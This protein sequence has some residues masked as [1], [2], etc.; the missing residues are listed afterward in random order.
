M[1]PTL[2]KKRVSGTRFAWNTG[3]GTVRNA[4]RA[5]ELRMP[6]VQKKE[7]DQKKLDRCR[8]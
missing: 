5:F 3:E 6:G 1:G 7:A 4:G 8:Y 2:V